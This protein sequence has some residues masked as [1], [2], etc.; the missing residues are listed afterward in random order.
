MFKRNPKTRTILT[1]A[2]ILNLG[3]LGTA[4]SAPRYMAVPIPAL[5]GDNVLPRSINNNG[6]ITGISGYPH[7]PGTR[8]F[9]WERSA[10]KSRNLGIIGRGDEVEPFSINDS[11]QI[12]GSLDTGNSV[13]GFQWSQGTPLRRLTQPP[14]YTSS[15]A[16]GINNSSHIAGSLSGPAGMNAA[17]WSPAG[18]ARILAA[19]PGDQGSEATAINNDGLIVGYS[20][21]SGGARAV[22]WGAGDK[23]QDLGILPGRTSSKALAINDKGQVV[24]SSA[25]FGVTRAFLWSAGTMRDL[26]TLRGGKYN[27]A[28]AINNSGQV[29]GNSLD[30]NG[31]TRAFLWTEEHG[32]EDL[33]FLVPPSDNLLLVAALDIND[34]GQIVALGT[35]YYDV[36]HDRRPGVDHR[37]HISPTLAFLLVPLP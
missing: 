22:L 11:N 14:G 7:A 3:G 17:A 36:A 5:R 29:V 35:I 10:A 24:G 2:F 33:N 21:G 30:S 28:T 37:Q 20:T 1:A 12:V 23:T 8:G 27:V 9:V 19:L 26:G 18:I 32:L 34:K 15:K 6:Y 31:E 16:Y 25:G 4:H 13:S